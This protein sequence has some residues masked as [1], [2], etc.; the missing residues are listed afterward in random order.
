MGY[1]ESVFS[2]AADIVCSAENSS[3]A[4]PTKVFEDL[5]IALSFD[6]GLPRE[7]VRIRLAVLS[8]HP[9]STLTLRHPVAVT[10]G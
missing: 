1:S 7:E 5:I 6:S 8:P 10:L 3:T 2:V 9:H 4:D